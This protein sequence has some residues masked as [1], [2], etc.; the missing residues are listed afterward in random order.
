M[1]K[2]NVFMG[3]IYNLVVDAVARGCGADKQTRIFKLKIE[4]L[5]KN[6]LID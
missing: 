3:K 5:T 6:L 4:V 1:V 2:M